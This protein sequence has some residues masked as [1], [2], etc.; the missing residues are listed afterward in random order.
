MR[1]RR[2]A[3]VGAGIAGLGAA[4]Q[5]ARRGFEV[6]VLEAG[7]GPGGRAWSTRV[8]GF[9]LEPGATLLSSGDRAL[10]SWIREVGVHDE[11]L[12]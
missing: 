5:L 3:V 1:D 2:V 4:W 9:T 12:P 11:L 7:P 10:L 6:T 8:D